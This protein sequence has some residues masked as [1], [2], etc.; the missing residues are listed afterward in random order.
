[1]KKF[2][3]ICF[4]ASLLTA[5]F[6]VTGQTTYTIVQDVNVSDL[7]MPSP[8]DKCII[9]IAKGITLTVNQDIF[10]Q[11]TVFNGG[12]VV[13]EKKAKITFWGSGQFNGTTVLFKS[14]SALVSS[15]ELTITNSDFIFSEKA[16]ATL[17]STAN[18]IASKMKFLDNASMEATSI[19]NLSKTSALIAGDGSSQSKAFI[20]FNGGTLN[21]Y[22]NSYVTAASFNNYY[23]NWSNYN[24]GGKSIQT[25]DNKMNCGTPG[26]NPCN[27]PAVYGPATLDSTGIGSFA[28]LPVKLTSFTIKSNGN[29]VNIT[30]TSNQEINSNRFQI[31]RS[32]DGINWITAGSVVAKGNS[33]ELS[34][35]SFSESFSANGLL[36]YRLKMI[37]QDESFEYSPIRSTKMA[38]SE[39]ITMRIYPNPATGYV[40]ISSNKGMS[41]L[42]IQLM[43]LN[44]QVIKQVNGGLGTPVSV[45]EFRAGNYIVRVSDSTGTAQNFKL[46]IAK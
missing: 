16:T 29:V 26:K 6:S 38:V 8:C 33:S 46:T 11:N 12:T 4:L 5:T 41:N 7:K 22:D 14:S 18:L 20:K 44:G 27:A 36:S 39:L 43:N 19:V 42:K 3:H 28:T 31:E 30:W 23:F 21:E 37:D 35:Y 32:A 17:W 34:T 40:V 2:L 10:L 13:I 15:G 9:N 24:A 1:M 25:K 45:S